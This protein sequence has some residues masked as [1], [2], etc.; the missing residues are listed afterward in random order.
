MLG[1][2]SVFIIKVIQ[3]YYKPIYYIMF[4]DIAN[5]S[6]MSDYL[7]LFI[8]V[9]LTDMFV[10]L[11]LN[12]KMFKSLVLKEWYNTYNL[13]A[14]MADVLIIF[15]V[16]ILTRFLYYRLFDKFSIVK[17]A[18]LAVVLQ[19]IHDVLFYLFLKNIPRGVNRMLDTFKDYANEVS[20]KAILSDSGMMIMASLIASYLASKDVN[21]NFIIL[22]GSLYILPYLLYN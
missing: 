8:G 21:T 11:L 19:V 3:F 12:T 15:L 2:C 10:I 13:S 6:N 14:V 22:I 16:L 5:F 7:P 20:Y 1:L 9:L 4:Q 17:F 18:A